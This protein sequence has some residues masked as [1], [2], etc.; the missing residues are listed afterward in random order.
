MAEY[1]VG[2]RNALA[3]YD[4]GVEGKARGVDALSAILERQDTANN[5]RII[6]GIC[7]LVIG[8]GMV[9]LA[10][11]SWKLVGIM[12]TATA[13]AVLEVALAVLLA[14]AVTGVLRVWAISN[15]V[16]TL[17]HTPAEKATP[18]VDVVELIAPHS[19]GG[20]LGKWEPDVRVPP[21]VATLR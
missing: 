16:Q 10:C 9:C 11:F 13:V 18:D 17:R 2:W 3:D 19:G 4:M 12:T 21:T 15:K 14:I 8:T 7:Q 1:I 20:D 6:A 5:R